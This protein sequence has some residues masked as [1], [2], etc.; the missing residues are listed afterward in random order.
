MA[1]FE[2]LSRDPRLRRGDAPVA[3]DQSY[4]HAQIGLLRRRRRNSSQSARCAA[5]N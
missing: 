5:E 3:L 1:G 2:R 4:G